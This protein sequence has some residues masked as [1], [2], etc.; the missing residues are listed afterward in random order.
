MYSILVAEHRPGV[1]P[2]EIAIEINKKLAAPNFRR[3]RQLGYFQV[4]AEQPP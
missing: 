4:I 3:R 1:D 2:F